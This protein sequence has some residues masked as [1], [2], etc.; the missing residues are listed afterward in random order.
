MATIMTD[1]KTVCQLNFKMPDKILKRI[2]LAQGEK[3]RNSHSSHSYSEYFQRRSRQIV[4][5]YVRHSEVQLVL[6]HKKS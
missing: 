1:V 5:K 4:L 6:G 3:R 2:C